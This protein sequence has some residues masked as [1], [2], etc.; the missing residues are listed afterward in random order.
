MRKFIYTFAL[1]FTSLFLFASAPL[2]AQAIQDPAALTIYQ[3]TGPITVDGVLNESDWAATAPHLMFKV[4]G[5]TPT[6]TSYTTTGGAVIKPPYT[7]SSVTFVKF[8]HYNNTLYISLKSDD[9]Q[10]CKFDWEGDGMFMVVKNASAQNSEL[11]LYVLN[12]TTFGAETGGTAPIPAGSYGGVGVVD[13][14]IYD[15]SD[16][17]NGYTAEAFIDLS[18]LGFVTTPSSLQLFMNI[19][20]PDNFSVGAPPWGPNGNFAKQ[21]W[22]SEWG[23]EL[24]TL[25]IV[26][27]TTPFDPASLPVFVTNDVIT[28]D[29]ILNEA[30]WSVDVPHLMFKKDALP[31]GNSYTPTA[32]FE[33]KPPYTDVSTCYVKFLRSGYD[34]YI[35]LNSNDQQVCRFDWEGDGMFMKIKNFSGASEYEIKSYVGI[36][37]GVGQFVFETNAPAG[38]TEGVGYAKPGTTIY[39]SS[40]VD[41]G[42]STEVV[43]H[44]D[45]LGYTDP[46][47]P[48]SLLIN[49]FDP[50][51]YSIGAPPWGPNGNFYKQWWGSE[52][53]G[54]YRTLLPQDIFVP[55]ELTSFTGTF[56]GNDIQLKWS[57]ST[58]LNNRGFEVQ[59]NINNAGFATIAFVEGKGTTTEKQQYSFVDYSVQSRVNY[60]YRLKQI[61][62]NG[63]YEYSSVINLGFTLPLE[64]VLEQNYPNPF[65]PT[66]NILYTVPVKSDVTLEVYNLLGQ[67][68]VT[69]VNE[70]VEAGKHTAQFNATSMSSG[71]YLFKLTAIGENG[72]QFTSSKKMTLL[73]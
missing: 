65:N 3:A 58:E 25:N 69:L 68:I 52:W 40:D 32:G 6:G 50:D 59:R 23:S 54:T 34:L 44:L 18:A 57:T 7:D 20:D 8:L 55:V 61:D 70:K 4:G 16:V 48:V 46:L 42:Y 67:K 49:I 60:S 72:S 35:S 17:D 51:N 12:A 63:T 47:A 71:I 62:Y 27:T 22:G 30:S 11:K 19:F 26:Q 9:M 29:G 73:K 1:I 37:G 64:F 39:D 45:Q 28:L 36:V 38:V 41:A 53:G 24:R 56:V 13:G 31:T 15:S 10:V 2:I 66:T 5:G 43:I 33:V 21:W 14:T